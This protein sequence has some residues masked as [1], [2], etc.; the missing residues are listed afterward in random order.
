MLQIAKFLYK[1]T[2]PVQ[3]FKKYIFSLNRL[4]SCRVGSVMFSILAD[5]DVMVASLCRVATPR[6]L[7]STILLSPFPSS[8][9]SF[10]S[11]AIIGNFQ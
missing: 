10:P 9:P 8:F 5:N 7:L 1:N 2:S 3:K 6:K 4:K 11:Q